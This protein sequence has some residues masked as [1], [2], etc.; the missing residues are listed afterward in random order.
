MR[1]LLLCCI[2][3]L[4]MGCTTTV[5]VKLKFPEA[6]DELMVKCPPLEKLNEDSKLSDIAKNVTKN[7]IVY[8][9]CSVLHDEFIDWYKIQKK[10]FEEVK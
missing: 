4:L 9:K 5:P 3:S 2:V 6:P 1:P 8:H 7:Y 10:M